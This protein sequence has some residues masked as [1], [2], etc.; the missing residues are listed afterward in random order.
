MD[1]NELRAELHKTKKTGYAFD[2]GEEISGIKCIGAPI[3]DRNGLPVAA[4]WIT[5]PDS[6]LPDEELK[7]KGEI[8]KKY[9]GVISE[10]L[11]Y[12]IFI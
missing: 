6:R 1:E 4:I 9:A 2:L 5:G 8:V 7:E 12:N 3:F 10:R 11:G